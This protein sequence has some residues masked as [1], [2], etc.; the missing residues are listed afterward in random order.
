MSAAR[1]GTATWMEA[2][3]L[4]HQCSELIHSKQ[5]AGNNVFPD[6]HS[7]PREIENITSAIKPRPLSG[8][9]FSQLSKE[10]G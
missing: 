2:L 6:L 8:R 7:V 10:M 1:K 9:L 5:L 4:E 3:A